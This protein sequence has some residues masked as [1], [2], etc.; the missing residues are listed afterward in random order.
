MTL[1]GTGIYFE[2]FEVGSLF[3]LTFRLLLSIKFK[4]RGKL[5]PHGNFKLFFSSWVINSQL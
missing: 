3:I 5:H 2:D 4:K 1:C